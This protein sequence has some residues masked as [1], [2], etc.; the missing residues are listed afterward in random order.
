[1]AAERSRH[2]PGSR[3]PSAGPGGGFARL[4]ARSSALALDRD[5]PPRLRQLALGPHDRE[6]STGQAQRSLVEQIAGLPAGEELRVEAVEALDLEV[7]IAKRDEAAQ[8]PF[9]AAPRTVHDAGEGGEV[10]RDLLDPAVPQRL[11]REPPAPA[12]ALAADGG[13]PRPGLSPARNEAPAAPAGGDLQ[14]PPLAKGDR[15]GNESRQGRGRADGVAR[16]QHHAVLDPVG[17]E[18]A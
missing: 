10:E 5:A 16:D 2:R 11:E 7:G 8:Q 18:G 14:P 15:L 12:S 6:P 17:E 3:T 4:R 9:E 1:M 13:G